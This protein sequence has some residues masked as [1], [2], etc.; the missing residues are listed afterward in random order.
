VLTQSL[1]P[2]L[3]HLLH[4]LRETLLAER[5]FL[6]I[7]NWLREVL[8]AEVAGDAIS[9]LGRHAGCLL[10]ERLGSVVWNAGHLRRELLSGGSRCWSR[11]SS[12]L[13]IL[14]I[15]AGRILLLYIRLS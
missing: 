3:P 11:L 15:S 8:L 2:R 13:T 6:E 7:E 12:F 10:R 5:L 9:L 14:T 1:L 4:V